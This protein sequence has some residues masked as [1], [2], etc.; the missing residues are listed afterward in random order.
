MDPPTTCCSATRAACTTSPRAGSGAFAIVFGGAPSASHLANPSTGVNVTADP[1]FLTID[2]LRTASTTV[3]AADTISAGLGN[4]I[5]F[6]GR[7]GDTIHGD[8]GNDL[9]FGD[10]A[11]VGGIVDAAQL[12]LGAPIA[13]QPFTFVSADTTDPNG[14]ADTITGDGGDDIALG[15]QGGDTI[16]G[17]DGDDDLI[18]GHNVALGHDGA[19]TIDGGAGN[20]VAAGDNASILRGSR[21]TCGSGT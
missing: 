12:P 5:V 11:W 20:D 10:F 6:G 14:G 19:D 13:G 18:G 17:G 2:V 4:D 15:R 16:A 1:S 3:G 21:R 8:G 7:G 9:L